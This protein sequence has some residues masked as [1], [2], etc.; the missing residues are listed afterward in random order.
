MAP[1]ITRTASCKAWNTQVEYRS[2]EY[3]ESHSDVQSN[4]L[5]EYHGAENSRGGGYFNILE[6]A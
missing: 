1:N 3:M 4:I 5:R 6:K 2:V